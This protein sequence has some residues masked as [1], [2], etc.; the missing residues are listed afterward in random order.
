MIQRKKTW[1]FFW[2]AT[3][4][5]ASDVA[6]A[7]SGSTGQDAMLS[8]IV[9]TAQR[10]AERLQEVPVSVA[11]FNEAALQVAN[12]ASLSDVKALV[13]AL[14]ADSAFG[15]VTPF[16]RGIGNPATIVGNEASV[17]VYVDGVYISRL[18]PAFFEFNNIDRIEVLKGPQG[19]LFG[20]NATGGLVQLITRDPTVEPTISGSLTYENY[21]TIKSSIYAGA[22]AGPIAGDVAF[23][24]NDQGEGWGRNITTAGETD[25][26]R[27]IGAR[28]K[29]IYTL[30]RDGK[31]TLQADYMDGTTQQ[32][33]VQNAYAGF[34][35]GNPAVTGAAYPALGIYDSRIEHP[36]IS[37]ARV[38]GGSLQY[39]HDFSFAAFK[40]IAAYRETKSFISI[41]ADFSPL[42]IYEAD[43]PNLVT[44]LSEEMQLA[45]LPSS[46]VKWLTGL[47]YLHL[48]SAYVPTILTGSSFVP[49]GLSVNLYGRQIGN[50]YAAYG[51]TTFA[52]ASETNLTLGLRYNV[53]K[54]EGSGRTDVANVGG[55]VIV[56]GPESYANATFDKLTWHGSL[57]HQ[58]SKGIMGYASLSRGFKAGIFNLQP[59]DGTP[60]QPETVDTG[61]IGAK[62]EIWDHRVRLNGSLF[63]NHIKDPQ[64]QRDNGSGVELINAGDAVTKGLDVD[65]DV[66]PVEH[67]KV[68][69][70]FT[71][72]SARYTSFDGAPYYYPNPVYPFGNLP[73]VVP[74]S[75]DGNRMPKA[76][77]FVFNVGV[78]YTIPL[79]AGDVSMGANYWHTSAFYWT[80]DN[81][82]AQSSYGLLSMN[83]AYAPAGGHW[84]FKL[85]GNNLTGS[86]YYVEMNELSGAAGDAGAPGA[87]RTYG[88]TAD[89]K[90]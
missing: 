66:Q 74:G 68:L 3:V 78:N 44:Q 35:Q 22:G 71:W 16:L 73:N 52:V 72:M 83:L 85:I 67:L 55:P 20:R 43:E 27:D 39:D 38:G 75:A 79:S 45:S 87:P 9:V 2:L 88:I 40:D 28:T 31:I 46:S 54:I 4:S 76:P 62:T 21:Q 23:I 32:G 30:P 11:A 70:G 81:V 49:P 12:V 82:V 63:Y 80:A 37:T 86:K 41:D 90:Y 57:D 5:A 50:T 10:R 42:P 34:V 77:D 61:E 19:T 48:N 24:Y 64:V 6:R 33:L 26:E 17:P 15:A 53:D 59:F 36:L 58:F 84:T 29:W 18:S 8:N 51:Q 60:I 65:G 25:K 89:F 56:P 7:Q 47:Y 14:N 1:A 13:P 69:F